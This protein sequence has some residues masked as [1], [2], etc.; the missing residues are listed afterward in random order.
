[1]RKGCGVIVCAKEKR[2]ATARNA[3]RSRRIKKPKTIP[4]RYKPG[5]LAATDRRH[6]EAKI[7]QSALTQFVTALGG[8]EHISPQQLAL[9]ERATWLNFWCQ[10]MEQDL[11]AGKA[12][13]PG[14]YSQLVNSLLGTLKTIGIHR[15]AKPVRRLSEVIAEHAQQ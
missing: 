5:F 12:V 1:M 2:K 6:S 15:V 7:A 14:K 8:P 9:C 3:V 11:L 10:R 4:A 13:D